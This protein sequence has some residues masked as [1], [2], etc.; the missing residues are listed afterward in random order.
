MSNLLAARLQMAIS[1]GFHII[2]AVIAMAMPLLMVVAEWRFIR[3][4]D[5]LYRDLA[6]R[7]CK[8]TAI[9]FA[10]GAVSGTVLSFELGLLWPTFMKHA[11]P[12]IGMP[13]SM[14]GFAFFLEA[15][16]L[17]IYLYGWERVPPRAHWF[18]GVMVLVSGTL[19]GIFVVCANAWMNTPRGFRI[20]DHKIVDID[21][22]AAMFNPA[23]FSQ[24]LHMTLA[25]FASVGF[26]VAAVHAYALLKGS[27]NAFHRRALEI[28]LL[29][30][31]VAALGQLV[32]GDI[33]AKHVAKHQPIKFAA[34]EAHWET[35]RGAPARIGGWPDQKREITRF[36]IEIPYL[37]SVLAFN[38]PHAEVKGLKS[39]PRELRPPVLVTH[40]AFQLMVGCGVFLALVALLAGWL[41]LRKID[42]AS[43][44]WFLR[45]LA[46]SGPL[47]FIAIEAGWTV[48]EV[49]R[50]PYVIQGLMRTR[51]A[52]TPMPALII[53]LV[54]FCLLYLFLGAIV[55]VLLKRHVFLTVV[56]AAEAPSVPGGA[57]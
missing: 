29:V 13:F 2:F 30:G 56:P 16:F 14:E 55:A 50:Q 4:G 31:A 32:S 27:A 10:V 51:S 18:S 23:A 25:A 1:L 41:R 12:V 43:R 47:G 37:L 22:W 24:A 28:A 36:S 6:K 54:A 20:V 44:R 45:L 38:D 5:A 49:G 42:V 15:I 19:S 33:S 9:M 8:G 34:L 39:V 11:G 7:W 35:T 48:T 46:A 57:R 3:T 26:A 17:G 52:V 40:L 21:V 53:P